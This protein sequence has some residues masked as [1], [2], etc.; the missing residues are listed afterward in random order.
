MPQPDIDPNHAAPRNAFRIIGPLLIIAG[1]LLMIFGGIR[2]FSPAWNSHSATDGFIEG[3]KSF[4]QVS[5]DSRNTFEDNAKTSFGGFGMVAGGMLTL[6]VGLVLTGAGN[7]GRAARY[8][9]QEV[10]PV[11]EDTFNHVADA[12]QDGVRTIVKSV[13][14]GIAQGTSH[15]GTAAGPATSAPAVCPKCDARNEAAAKFCSQCGAAMSKQCPACQHLNAPTA[16]F[17]DKCG[18][19]LA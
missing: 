18:Q 16:R 11:A 8:M 14:E 7:A 19:A 4:D 9:S 6:V 15:A 17:C 1:L 5:H 13:S 10:T 3:R 2:M 12:T